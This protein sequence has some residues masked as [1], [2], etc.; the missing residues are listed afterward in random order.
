[1]NRF[2]E[3]GFRQHP[4]S[5]Q[6]PGPVQAQLR[7]ALAHAGQCSGLAVSKKEYPIGAQAKAPNQR[8]YRAG[9]PELYRVFIIDAVDRT[10]PNG[11]VSYLH[12]WTPPVE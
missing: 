11:L 5:L 6:T 2:P 9:G 1:V 4:R 12:Q 10:E 8:D 7:A 3:H